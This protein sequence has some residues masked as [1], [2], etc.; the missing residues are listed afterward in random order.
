MTFRVI[1]NSAQGVVANPSPPKGYYWKIIYVLAWII[2]GSTTGTRTISVFLKPLSTYYIL[3]A[4]ELTSTLAVSGDLLGVVGSTGNSGLNSGFAA[5]ESIQ[6][7]EAP[8]CTS[9]ITIYVSYGL[10]SGDSS[11]F[12]LLVDE[13]AL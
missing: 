11:G 2:E 5:Q 6:W 13:V 9:D 12:E 8:I 3:L 4:P 10:Q 7:D 1:L